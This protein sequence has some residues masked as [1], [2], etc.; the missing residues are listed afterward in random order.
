MSSTSIAA[1]ADARP[2]FPARLASVPRRPLGWV[3]LALLAYVPVLRT[4]PGNVAADTKQYLYLDPGRLLERAAS[5]W[6]PNV[7]MGSVT[8]QTIGYLFP[9]GPFYWLFERLGVPDWVAQRLWLGSILF[10]AAAGVLVLLRSFGMRGPGVAL[11]AVAYMLSPYSLDYAARI[12]VLLLPWAALP[13]MITLMRKALADGGWRYPAAFALLVQ[14]VGGV[15]A[16]ALVFAG[17][18]PALW[19]A[20]AW[21]FA[22]DV[23]WRRALAVTCKTG[24]LTI[25][26]SLW[27]IAGLSI[28]GGYGLNILRYTETV[29]AVARTSTPNE[30][31]RGLGYWFFYGQD[32]LGPWIEASSNYTQRPAVIIAGYLLA[33]L[34]LLA[35]AV[36]RWRHRV[37]FVALLLAGVVIAVGAHPYHSPTPL[38]AAFKAFATSSTAGLALRSTGRAV[39]LVVLATAV[40]L[41]IGAN[42]VYDG[43]RR[44]ARPALAV[45]SIAVV[46]TLVA[47]N[48]P[49]L[50]DETFYGD[51]LQRPE[52]LPSY[53][54]DA[55]RHLD[56]RGDGTRVLELPGSDFASYRWGNT[57]DPI[58]PGLMDRPYV[59]RELIPYGS[60]G[61]ADLLNALDRR[62]Q[63]G[64]FDDSGFA[65]LVRRMG[66]G[67]VV[68][69]NDIQYERY[70]LVPPRELARMFASVP[71]L[72]DPTGFGTPTEPVL[73]KPY[74]DERALRA[75]AEEPPPFPVVVYPVTDPTR[76]V[77]AESEH[78]ALMVAGDGEGLVDVAD[79]GL[80]DEAGVVRYSASYPEAE[81]L[82]A[83][84]ADGT[85]LVL[86]DSNRRRARRWSTV[87]DNVGTT[88]QPGEE[89]LRQDL[90]DA[91]LD[92]FPG[93][94]AD[95][96]TVVD[97]RGVRWVTATAYGNVISYTPE[98]RAARAF[99]GDPETAWR[100]GGFGAAIGQRLHVELDEPLTASSI[101][102]VQPVNGGRDRFVTEVE[103]RFDGGDAVRARLDATSRT[104][105]GQRIEFGRRRFR[106]L[107]IEVTDVNVGERRWHGG[108]DA[109]GFAEVR[110]R[111][112]VTN[113]AVRVDEVVRMPEDLLSA[114]GTDSAAHP[115]VVVMSRERIDP[116]PP[117]TDP[118]PAIV[119]EFSLP[120]PRSFELTGTARL[121]SEAEHAAIDAA[122][123]HPDA[124][125]GGVTTDA[126]EFLKGC[127]ACRADAALDGDPATAWQT[128]FRG[129][130]G[131][132][133][134]FLLADPVTFDHLDL[135]VVADGRHSVPTRLRLEV[136]GGVRDLVVPP[137][138]DAPT[139]NATTTVPLSFDAIT[140]RHIRVTIVDVREQFAYTLDGDTTTLLPAAIAELGVPGATVAR[141]PAR[142][143]ADC[144]ADLLTIDDRPHR[145]RIVGS[146][147]DAEAMRPLAIESCEG[148]V[149]L[150]AGRH[151]VRAAPGIETAV[152]L[153]RVVL[154]SSGGGQELRAS[155]GVVQ[156]ARPPAA[157]LPRVDVVDDG[158]TRMRVRVAGATEPFWLVLGQSHSD[159]WTA[160]VAGG[161]GLGTPQLVDGYANGWRI[162]PG[163]PTFDVVVEWTPQRRVWASIWISVVAG[164]ACALL[165]ALTWRRA[166]A[167]SLPAAG[168]AD[169]AIEVVR[170]SRGPMPRG[171]RVAAPLAAG[172][173][174]AIVAAP[175]MGAVVAGAVAAVLWRPGV[176]AALVLAPPALLTIAALYIVYGQ[177]RY[178]FD[179]IFEWP[180]LFPRA[181]TL[182]WLAVVLLVGDAVIEVFLRRRRGHEP[183]IRRESG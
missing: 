180:T 118:E 126:R 44:A 155:G 173:V 148:P 160:S 20:Y 89:A 61:T 99:D 33:A 11:A 179:P 128:P 174:A 50:V 86:T 117:R 133:A 7:G 114:L 163:R 51:N 32:R 17:V 45:A 145:V 143:P 48:F 110:L 144:R 82:R 141:L 69:R 80:L 14:V 120:S 27:W 26:T 135:A 139:E 91:R 183:H 36:V 177:R 97:Q 162:E 137:V 136:D 2:G 119:R 78:Y 74:L 10:A 166:R 85:V 72:G 154:A 77:R 58:T 150:G 30:V 156:A 71:G 9:M 124:T 95:A 175:W 116:V 152:Q 98:D 182:G 142:L 83:A 24:T 13:W 100:G 157:P 19:V 52:E 105:S 93:Q 146:T 16:T 47:V 67:D 68:L 113:R 21:L 170:V 147:S 165:V 122:L 168:D 87:L 127:V 59:A 12:S 140:G 76:I 64:V 70:D 167:L 15:N 92:V 181:R 90:G 172:L 18:G 161:E 57:V 115:L 79:L 129:V 109:V 39:P 41:G 3:A 96:Q 121:T 22:R 37:Y 103:L 111:D 25:A 5:M 53:W 108:A 107:D 176:R 171:A 159:G 123:G 40:F 94:R 101:E 63:E 49:A 153:D 31:L 56:A 130:R 149:E 132:W 81:E 8:H 54:I 6:D 75:P 158:R 43:L 29:E 1:R 84:V 138:T 178:E 55:T 104:P 62:I 102:V 134:D 38:G 131:Q 28:Q 151:I 169:V 42:A 112:E 66:V 106:A 73:A 164:L 34:A 88:E 60:P 65:A 125:A 35:A 46:A 23:D 4:A